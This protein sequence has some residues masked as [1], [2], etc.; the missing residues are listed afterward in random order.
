MPTK[1]LFASRS[2]GGPGQQR[3]PRQSPVRTVAFLAA[4]TAILLSAS[5]ARLDAYAPRDAA[6]VHALPE[7]TEVKLE[8]ARALVAL[9][10]NVDALVGA[11]ARK[12]RVS[13]DATR[14]MVDAAY[15]EAGRNG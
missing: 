7:A 9:P 11:L 15:V 2:A 8:P 4:L 12:Y 6:P 1:L 3:E 14:E 10:G 13:A 5:T